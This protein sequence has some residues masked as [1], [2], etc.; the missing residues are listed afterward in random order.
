[1]K[2][3]DF[4]GENAVIEDLQ[5]TDKESV[6]REMVDVLKNLD[7]I[8]E[9]ELDDIM[10]A[11]IKREKVG[12]TGIGKGVAVPHTKHQSIKKITGAFARS[13]NGVEFDAL[14]GEP[15]YLFFLLLS[16]NN[17]TD[18]HLSALEKISSVIRNPDFRNF[19]RNA[20][21][22]SEMVDIL[23]EVDEAKT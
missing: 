22:K 13:K 11:L 21:N 2:I 3:M 6:I 20:S 18:V 1:M 23:K 19:V 17:S 15:V 12:S 4:I 9:N 7:M 8:N 5:S 16:P 14:D 10:E